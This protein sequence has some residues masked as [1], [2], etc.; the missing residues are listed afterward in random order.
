MTFK[1]L[2]Q[3]QSNYLHLMRD[4]DILRGN[5]SSVE[6]ISLYNVKQNMAVE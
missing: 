4:V 6:I 2:E 5:A 1:Q 3:E